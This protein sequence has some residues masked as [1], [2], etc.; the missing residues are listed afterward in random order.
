MLLLIGF[1]VLAISW[2]NFINLFAIGFHEQTS[3]MAV[4]QINGASKFHIQ[5]LTFQKGFLLS[6]LGGTMAALIA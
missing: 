6:F 4:H 2:I 5:I 3:D 1:I